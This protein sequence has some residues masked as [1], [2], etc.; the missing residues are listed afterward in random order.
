MTQP[1]QNDAIQTELITRSKAFAFDRIAYIAK[2]QPGDVD[3]AAYYTRV[4]EHTIAMVMEMTAVYRKQSAAS[5]PSCSAQSDSKS[6]GKAPRQ[7]SQTLDMKNFKAPKQSAWEFWYT[8]VVVCVI[9]VAYLIAS[10]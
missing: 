2:R 8:P 3:N 10:I 5:N 7:F 6:D 1:P 4:G 9:F